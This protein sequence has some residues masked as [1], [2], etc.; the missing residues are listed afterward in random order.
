MIQTGQPQLQAKNFGMIISP[1][2]YIYNYLVKIHYMTKK[3]K[4]NDLFKWDSDCHNN[5]CINQYHQPWND[6]V[7]GYRAA[8]EILIEKILSDNTSIDILVYPV[9][10]LY[11]HCLELQMKE[12][13]FVGR[14]LIG[15]DF[16]PLNDHNLTA[17]WKKLKPLIIEIEPTY[18]KNELDKID[19]VITNFELVDKKSD[20]FRYSLTKKSER[21][22]KPE[23][24]YI[25]IRHFAEEMEPVLSTLECISGWFSTLQENQTV[26]NF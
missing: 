4:I 15:K 21:T 13:I 11:R 19:S 7:R 2:N 8:T 1:H 10:F 25:N 24:K 14:H 9:I 3:E 23:L 26:L 20:E 5:A 18:P 12:I 6:Y 22:L 16:E 17:L